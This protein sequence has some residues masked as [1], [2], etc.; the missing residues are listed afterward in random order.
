M[1]K[2]CMCMYIRVVLGTGDET[3]CRKCDQICTVDNEGSSKVTCS[4]Y[5]GYEMASNN[6]CNDIDEWLV[7]A[8]I[9]HNHYYTKIL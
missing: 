8:F 4:C 7:K 5:A 9:N 2:C 3:E 1:M 6:T